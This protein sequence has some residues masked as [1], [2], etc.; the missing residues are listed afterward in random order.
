MKQVLGLGNALVDILVKLSSEGILNELGMQKGSMT[1]IDET[2]LEKISKR[3]PDEEKAYATGGSAAN[4]I[5]GLANL[6]IGT[7]FIGK[8]GKDKT[9]TFF[10][11][12]M[13]N[14]GIV[15]NLT[16]SATTTGQA[17]AMIT[18]DSE[19]TFGTYLGAAVELSDN[20]LNPDDFEGYQILYVEGYLVFNKPLI[21]AGMK[22]AQKAGMKIA[23][24][25]ASYNVVEAEREFIQYLVD[26]YVDILFANEEEAKAFSGL[27]PE[28]ALDAMGKMVEIAV[29]KIGAKGALV[30]A[31]GTKYSSQAI[32]VTPIDTTGAG[33]LFAAG[34][35]YGMLRGFTPDK[36]AKTGAILGGMVI[37]VLGAKMDNKRWKTIKELIATL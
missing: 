17:F 2:F 13:K 5:N 33:D 14:S 36:C 37:E 30:S 19:R 24:D 20:D 9:G 10:E 22:I 28:E 27:N 4:T 29:V 7:G 34:Y 6:G 12:D 15:P 35:I 16:K 26:K 1:L 11:S 18:P 23:L 25:L 8:I 31:N 21:E 32:Q 3:I